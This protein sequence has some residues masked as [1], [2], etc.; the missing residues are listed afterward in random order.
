MRIRITKSGIFGAKG[1][2]AVGTEME[3]PAEPKG[4]KGR[5]VIL[6]AEQRAAVTN[7]AD[8]AV[9][10]P[11]GIDTDR[12]AL[13]AEAAK[14]LDSDHFKDSG[15]PDVRE[16]NGLLSDDAPKFTAAERDKLWPGIADAVKAARA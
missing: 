2:I 16:I 8:G 12:Q 11:Q 1:E 6:D 13:L 7:P 14:L 10:E 9:Q 4:W 15:M 5:Y 3:L